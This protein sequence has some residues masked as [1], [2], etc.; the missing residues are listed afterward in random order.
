MYTYR[1]E[2]ALRAVTI[3]H[4]DQVR[5][6]TVPIPYI[7]HLFSVAFIAAEYSHDEDVIIAA[8]LHDTLEDTD[9]TAKELEEDFGGRV[10]EI[11]ESL[12]EP[13]TEES[14]TLT[15]KERKIQ[16]AKTLKKG[17]EEALIV[18]AADKIHNMRAVVEE[19]YDDHSRFLADFEG[20]L[21][22]RI[23]MYEEISTVF[24]RNL[25]SPIVKEFNHVF[26]EYKNFINDVKKVKEQKERF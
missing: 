9:Y 18:A 2:Q 19:Y 4:K 1:I 3:L 13:K 22:D 8:L 16:Y 5:K 15:W 25:K 23:L 12:S 6:G 20:S 14:R 24:N 11:V 7:S 21:D 26:E 10:R 17:N